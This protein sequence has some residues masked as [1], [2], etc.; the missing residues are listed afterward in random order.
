MP[1]L[2]LFKLHGVFLDREPFRNMLQA[3]LGM[4]VDRVDTQIKYSA[5][6]ENITAHLA[7]ADEVSTETD[8]SSLAKTQDVDRTIEARLAA[9]A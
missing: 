7:L 3:F 8:V 5:P 6:K 4:V 2:A 9:L 1:V